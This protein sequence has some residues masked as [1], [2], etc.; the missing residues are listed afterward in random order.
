MYYIVNQNHQIIAADNDFLALLGVESINDLYH[1][2]ALET[3]KISSSEEE[4]ITISI[5]TTQEIYPVHTQTLHSILGDML[6]IEIELTQDKDDT[7]QSQEELLTLGSTEKNIISDIDHSFDAAIEEDIELHPAEENIPTPDIEESIEESSELDNIAE[8]KIMILDEKSVSDAIQIDP[9]EEE[10]E[11]EEETSMLLLENDSHSVSTETEALF[12]DENEVETTSEDTI[13]FLDEAQTQ[14]AVTTNNEEVYDLTLPNMAEETI[15]TITEPSSLS[16]ENVLEE[17]NNAPIIIDIEEISQQIGISIDDYNNFLNEYIDTA[18][19]LEEDLKSDQE[20]KHTHAISTL[21][22]LS[23]V[24]HLPMIT[25]IL[26]E[27]K[28]NTSEDKETSIQSLYN[29]LS[30][31]TTSSIKEEKEDTSLPEEQIETQTE[32][33]EEPFLL[34]EQASND[35]TTSTTGFGSIDLNDVHPIHFDFQLEEAANDLSLPV[36]LIEEFVHDFIEQAHTET[37]KMLDAYEKGDLETIQKIGH[38]LK[39]TS[40]NL[41]I[42]ALSDTLYK[43][44]FC[45]ESSQLEDFIKEYWAHFLAFEKQINLTSK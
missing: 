13:S 8:E 32:N 9:L 10:K 40:S 6:L 7:E 20:E 37:K 41:R 21:L 27:I 42:N 38:L 4:K 28:E 14:E 12:K 25:K 16:I 29:T 11:E 24:L 15:H 39:G 36:E 19:H 33:T 18:L 44:Q 35:T 30:R 5:D 26:T 23:S 17:E 31:L 22:H 1:K 2:V 43:I 45:E 3:I 34:D